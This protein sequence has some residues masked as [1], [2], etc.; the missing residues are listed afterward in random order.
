M[1]SAISGYIAQLLDPLDYRSDE[2]SVFP[3][4]LP[5][6]LYQNAWPAPCQQATHTRNQNTNQKPTYVC[7]ALS[8]ERCGKTVRAQGFL[9][10][11]VIADQPVQELNVNM[12]KA[13]VL[14]V[15]EYAK[16]TI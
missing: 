8:S 3:L 2:S 12:W 11:D 10:K 6:P 4:P 7:E 5:G 13:Q 9:N 16:K 15:N 14:V 1:R